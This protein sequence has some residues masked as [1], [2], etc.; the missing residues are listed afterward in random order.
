MSSNVI[1]SG[2][3]FSFSY[4]L[5]QVQKRY[6]QHKVAIIVSCSNVE[7]DIYRKKGSQELWKLT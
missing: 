4:Y 3:K 1:Y 7:M 2:E 6:N 5:K